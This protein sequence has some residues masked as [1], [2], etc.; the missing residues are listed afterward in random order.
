VNSVA[1]TPEPGSRDVDAPQHSVLAAAHLTR[2]LERQPACL[3][4]VGLDSVLL[5][6]ND[7]ALSLLGATQLGQVLG[8]A[9]TERLVPA[10]QALWPDFADR[11]WKNASGSIECDMVD[12][13]GA[14]RTVLVQGVALV[15]HPDGI[16]SMLATVRDVSANRHLETTLRGFEKT[17]PEQEA[18]S[19]LVNELRG[20]LEAALAE[21][22]VTARA[23]DTLRAQLEQ[24]V[25]VR[26]QLETAAD[27]DNAGRQRLESAIAQ[28]EAGRLHLQSALDESLAERQEFGSA[29][30]QRDANRQR[31]LAEHATARV[32]AES[33]LAEAVSHNEQLTQRLADQALD[34][35][36]TEDNARRL[37]ALVPAGH[38][39]LDAALAERAEAARA[40]DALRVQLEQANTDRVRLE[41]VIAQRDASRLEFQSTLDESLAEQQELE[42]TLKQREANRQRLLG[43][44]AEH[45]TARMRIESTLVEATSRNEQLAKLLADQ[46]LDRQ[47]TEENARRLEALAAAGQAALDAALHERAE[48]TLAMDALCVQLEQSRADRLR[49]QMAANQEKADRQRIESTIE[50]RDADRLQLEAAISQGDADRRH[51]QSTLDGSLA[52]RQ[53][54]ESSL[55]QHVLDSRRLEAAIAQ[56]DA[57]RRHLQ[58]TLDGSLAERQALESSLQQHEASRQRLL[59]EHAIARG[60]AESLLS[61]ATSHREGLTKLLADQGL[62]LQRTDENARR[63][64]S[65]A[66]AGRLALE[67]A[68]ELRT[69]VGVLDDRTKAL[70]AKCPLEA[71]EREDME[72]V[73]SAAIRAAS[74][75]RQ[76]V[77][78]E[79]IG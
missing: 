52:E 17:L 9:L 5:A 63:L 4:R 42:S 41:A 12:L 21:Q 46:D 29:L 51:L 79:R 37:E 24:S 34:L 55:Q 59:A 18:A 60:R 27:Q 72:T 68:G 70:L 57:D 31:L 47:R 40:L 6:T 7:A 14:A 25:A 16:E 69:V 2:L 28:H 30:K 38:Q 66:T 19:L 56:G 11:V 74:L 39:A 10:H 26:Q 58:S 67:V 3:M 32:R 33:A 76:I 48:A 36:R 71:D 78:V 54:L 13:S 77:Q 50:Q 73:R 8:T 35:Q 61:E 53:A 44:V 45:A 23:I 1:V 75:A 62:D 20:Q 64:E 43:L 49:L 22:T 65:L 15:D